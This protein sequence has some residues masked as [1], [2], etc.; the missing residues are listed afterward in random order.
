VSATS[1]PHER[2]KF[3]PL[4]M[5]YCRMSLWAY[6]HYLAGRLSRGRVMRMTVEREMSAELREDPEAF[7]RTTPS[8][9]R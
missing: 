5:P 2:F 4:D 6:R 9:G 8:W 1:L 7:E 3:L